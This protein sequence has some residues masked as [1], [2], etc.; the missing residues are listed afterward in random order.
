MFRKFKLT[1]K[2]VTV[3]LIEIKA[4]TEGYVVVSLYLSSCHT[5]FFTILNFLK[6]FIKDNYKIV[7]II[8]TVLH[9]SIPIFSK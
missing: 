5:L 9:Y 3:V 6:V 8:L 7:Q 4:T 1:Q 2:V